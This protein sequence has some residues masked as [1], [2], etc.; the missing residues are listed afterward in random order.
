MRTELVVAYQ[1]GRQLAYAA[2]PDGWTTPNAHPKAIKK[3][4]RAFPSEIEAR[5]FASKFSGPVMIVAEK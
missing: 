1:C 2:T 4:I 5:M 3:T